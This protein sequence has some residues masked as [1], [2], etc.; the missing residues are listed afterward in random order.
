MWLKFEMARRKYLIMTTQLQTEDHQ[1][2]KTSENLRS[3]E[4]SAVQC[5]L[6][7]GFVL[8]FQ[9]LLCQWRWCKVE[10][11]SALME[12]LTIANTGA[13]SPLIP[14]P[15]CCYCHIISADNESRNRRCWWIGGEKEVLRWSQ[16][17]GVTRQ[18]VRLPLTDSSKVMVRRSHW[19]LKT[20]DCRI[21]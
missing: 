6:T 15:A 10:P 7:V 11:A 16:Q 19:F 2:A 13:A 3:S 21:E 1:L 12:K 18:M 14:F 20:W 17:K 8:P 5:W 4:D 9:R